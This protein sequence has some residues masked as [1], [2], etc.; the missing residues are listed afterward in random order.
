MKK[1]IV[2]NILIILFI[3]SVGTNIYGFDTKTD[4]VGC[5]L[6]ER[7]QLSVIQKK[8]EDISIGYYAYGENFT[9]GKYKITKKYDESKGI[10]YLVGD[11]I[12]LNTIPSGEFLF[13]DDIESTEEKSWEIWMDIY[14]STDLAADNQGYP[15]KGD[16]NIDD[17][18]EPGEDPEN[19]ALYNA[20]VSN[21][22]KGDDFDPEKDGWGGEKAMTKIIKA[23][24]KVVDTA[25]SVA[26]WISELV[27]NPGGKIT[28]VLMD[29]VLFIAD[30]FQYWGSVFQTL[31]D[32][33]ATDFTVTYSY[34]DLVKDGQGEDIKKNKTKNSE[35]AIG[36]RDKYTKV[37]GYEESETKSW[38]KEIVLDKETESAYTKDIEIPVMVG[39]IYNAI[40]NHIDFFDTNFLTGN[41][42]T[43]E[44]KK[45]LVHKEGSTW[46]ILRNF[47]TTAIHVT[48]YIA[49]AV[50]ILALIY[51]GIRLVGQT[52]DNPGARAEY[53]K[54][55]ENFS[56]SLFML[57]GS[58]VIMALCIFGT[59]ALCQDLGNRT[60][61]E[62]PIRV[63]VENAEYSF[64]TTYTGYIRYIAGIEDIDQA[65][66][67]A[68]YTMAYLVLAILN[69]IAMLGMA[70]RFLA[71]LALAMI[72]P[73]TAAMHVF[74]RRAFIDYRSWI[75]LYIGFS[76]VP[77]FFMSIVYRLILATI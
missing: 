60:S 4:A 49:S 5:L 66:R 11:T 68:V 36:N 58:I 2:L 9:T 28:T 13:D 16:P 52:L 38:Q 31:G 57:I 70:V 55:L 10:I 65:L 18:T 39:D 26:N 77:I 27:D 34:D 64:S 61:K 44:D 73:L 15:G 1:K 19:T 50:L 45:T 32:N 76:V 42:D 7:E 54:G 40:V 8:L 47:A 22:Y 3:I 71:L 33:T 43:E 37:S 17:N 41:K 48:I 75:E 56:K 46:L 74:G 62:L 51:Y 6:I 21:C 67:K 72:G 53:K 23:I 29:G 30:A 63:K 24:K 69:F 59:K 20:Y 12:E 35:K 14:F 25:K